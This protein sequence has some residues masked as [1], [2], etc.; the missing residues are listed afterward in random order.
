MNASDTATGEMEQSESG[1]VLIQRRRNTAKQMSPTERAERLANFWDL[2]PAMMDWV[3]MLMGAVCCGLLH[4]TPVLKSPLAVPMTVGMAACCYM[5]PM[6]GFFFL[7]C[8]QFLPFSEGAALNPAQIGSVVWLPVALV[9]YQK[10]DLTGFGHFVWLAPWI[11]WHMLMT[12]ENVFGTDSEYVKAFAYAVIGLQLANASNGRYL[13]CVFGLVCGTLMVGFAYWGTTM[14][15]PIQVSD[16]GQD[17]EGFQR[18]GSVRA[19]AVMVWPALLMGF[20]GILGIAG[21]FGTK[22]A[23]EKPPRWLVPAVLV[24]AFLTLPPLVATMTH[25]AFA[26]L[27]IIVVVFLVALYSPLS[28]GAGLSKFRAQMNALMGLLAIGAVAMFAADA[29]GVRSRTTALSTHFEQQKGELGA[30]ASRT[31][32]WMDSIDTIMRY[33]LTGFRFVDGK[34]RITSHYAVDGSYL[35]HCVFLDYGRWGGLPGLMF[36][37]MFLFVPVK[38]LWGHP[39]RMQFTAFLMVFVAV[40]TF[41]MVLS[42]PFYKTVW[43]FWSLMMLAGDLPA[44]K[45]VTLGEAAVGRFGGKKPAGGL[46]AEKPVSEGAAAGRLGDEKLAAGERGGEGEQPRGLVAF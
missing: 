42:F 45:P 36:T 19:D 13:M 31:D 27:G 30:V 17:R 15:L 18:M 43:S 38:R 2:R 28:R 8:N 21:S 40:F 32:V 26:G 24:A 9:R 25:G 10:I 23:K 46:G 34:E 44:E 1:V 37:V 16:W 12:G 33:P 39:N 22:F 3:L 6:A 14:G 4:L 20:A 5:S 7:G 29:F 11:G 41:W 35:S